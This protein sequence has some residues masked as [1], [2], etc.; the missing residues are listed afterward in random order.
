MKPIL[1]AIQNLRIDGSQIRQ[2]LNKAKIKFK[3]E[4]YM[5]P[6]KTNKKTWVACNSWCAYF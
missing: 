4:M 5:R 1:T 6:P 2:I 3:Y